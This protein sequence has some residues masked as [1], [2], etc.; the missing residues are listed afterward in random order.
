[1]VKILVILSRMWQGRFELRDSRNML[2]LATHSFRMKWGYHGRYSVG[3]S[4]P[5]LSMGPTHLDLDLSK[6]QG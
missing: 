3:M 2:W 6:L 4:S 1:M 5:Q